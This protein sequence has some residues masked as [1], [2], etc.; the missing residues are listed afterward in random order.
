MF[1]TLTLAALI[2]SGALA[3]TASAQPPSAFE[4]RDGYHDRDR[5]HHRS[6]YQVLVRHRGHWDVHGTYRDRPEA[7]R[8]ARRLE[9]RGLDARV[10]RV[11]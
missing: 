11:W 2:A 5:D 8:V 7:Q 9:H 4:H 3:A 10:E 6:R 1:R